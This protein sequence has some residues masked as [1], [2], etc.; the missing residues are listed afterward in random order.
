MELES[1]EIM[2]ALG[3]VYG[4]TADATFSDS[5]LPATAGLDVPNPAQRW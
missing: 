2:V 4:W 1:G 5:F 3:V